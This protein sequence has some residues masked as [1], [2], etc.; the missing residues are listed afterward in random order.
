MGSAVRPSNPESSMSKQVQQYTVQ[1]DRATGEWIGEPRLIGTVDLGEW[2][3]C[4]DTET[5]HFDTY[6]VRADDGVGTI[7]RAVEIIWQ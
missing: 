1:A 7:T 2:N 5:A 4:Q 6:E 3:Q